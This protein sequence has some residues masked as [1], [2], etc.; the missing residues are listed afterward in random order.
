MQRIPIPSTVTASKIA[1]SPSPHTHCKIKIPLLNSLFRGICNCSVCMKK[2][3]LEP[4][5]QL[6]PVEEGHKSV[7]SLLEEQGQSADQE[8][9]PGWFRA[10]YD[11]LPEEDREEYEGQA[12]ELCAELGLK[13]DLV[14]KVPSPFNLFAD[15]IR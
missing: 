12:K 14:S 9:S 13:N 8:G 11:S 3:G 1:L 6:D 4:T 10:K 15:E 2:K 5:G 7:A